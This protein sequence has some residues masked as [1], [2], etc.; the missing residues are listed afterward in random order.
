MSS[1]SPYARPFPCGGWVLSLTILLAGFIW[2]KREDAAADL[3]GNNNYSN[4]GTEE[5]EEEEEE[6]DGSHEGRGFRTSSSAYQTDQ[7]VGD[8][9]CPSASTYSHHRIHHCYHSS[10]TIHVSRRPLPTV[11]GGNASTV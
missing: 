4:A 5:D 2:A 11:L 3:T 6:E 1:R 8:K 7:E 10:I 9:C